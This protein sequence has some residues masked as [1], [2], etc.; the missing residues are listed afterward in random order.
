MS[1][2]LYTWHRTGQLLAWE[3]QNGV[4]ESP[5]LRKSHEVTK[6]HLQ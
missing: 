4:Q 5:F 2:M 1:G 3:K 6:D